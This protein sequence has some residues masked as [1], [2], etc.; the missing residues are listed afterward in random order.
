MLLA[1]LVAGQTTYTQPMYQVQWKTRIILVSVPVYPTGGKVA[2][3][4]T[5]W[6]KGIINQSLDIWNSAQAWFVATYFPAHT[7]Q[8]YT[9]RLAKNGQTA[10]V[11]VSLVNQTQYGA[12]GWTT[13]FGQ[14]VVFGLNHLNMVLAAHEFGHVL[15]LGDN[16]VEND[17]L[18]TAGPGNGSPNPSTLDLYAAYLQAV[19]GNSLGEGDTVTLPATIPY[20]TWTQG[21]PIPEFPT[22][23]IMPLV[24]LLAMVIVI[25]RKR[26]VS[27]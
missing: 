2:V 16:S 27:T 19:S 21:A 5:N 25:V 7:G 13:N 12:V 3:D 18:N 9:L 20:S 22:V 6:A 15:G 14:Q 11:T 8:V 10:Q 26:V 1:P 17:L 24:L 23:G 4:E